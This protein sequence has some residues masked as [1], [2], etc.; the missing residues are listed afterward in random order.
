MESRW[1][2]ELKKIRKQN[3][4][5]VPINVTR[6]NEALYQI[7]SVATAVKFLPEALITPSIRR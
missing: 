4:K 1:K 3:T 5:L 2:E 6:T 7:T